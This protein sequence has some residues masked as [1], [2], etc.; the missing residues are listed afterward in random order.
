MTTTLTDPIAAAADAAGWW[1]D[2][3]PGSRRRV[4]AA[5]ADAL[6][7]AADE[8]VGLAGTESHLPEAR[9]RGELART[10]FQLRLLGDAAADALEP[11]VDAADPSWPAGGRPDLRRVLVPVGP[12]LVFA[13]SNFPFAFSVLG[14]DTAAALAAGCPVV[15]KVHPGHPALSARVAALAQEAIT[16][17]GAPAGTLGLVSGVDEG[18]T[19]LRDPRIAAGA[20]TG[21]P[22]GGRALADVA[23]ARARPIPFYAEMGSVNPVFVTP[24][25]A[26]ARAETVAGGFVDSYLLGAGQ[27]CTKPGLL[28]VPASPAGDDLVA[29]ATRRAGA[30]AAAPMLDDRIRDA[31]GAARTA[32][33][34]HPAV[35]VL[36][37]GAGPEDPALLT[38]DAATLLADPEALAAECFGPTSLVVRYR[39]EAELLVVA[40]HFVGELTATVHGEP[41]EAVAGELV[42]IAAGFAGRVLWN[43]W[44][45][46]VAVSHAQQHGGPYPAATGSFTSVGTTSIRRF[47]RPVAFQDVPDALLPPALRRANPLGLVRREDG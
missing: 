33:V 6:D 34:G 43:G 47:L 44:P 4:L 36:V 17:A 46:G 2:A 39:D 12:V 22:A 15:V 27:F 32:L 19:A 14:G 28:F 7:A 9:L 25:A 24:A 11:I 26:R 8:L 29:E 10:T 21:S 1:A 16:T 35:R 40:R 20:F 41:G 13:A 5:V 45:T 38:V 23:A 3:T 31:H 37:R 42:R 30:R 18:V